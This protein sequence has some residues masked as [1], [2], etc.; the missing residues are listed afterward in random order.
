MHFDLFGGRDENSIP[1]SAMDCQDEQK[2]VDDMDRLTVTN[3]ARDAPVP[4]THS[5]PEPTFSSKKKPSE[6]NP[7]L[8]G[9]RKPIKQKKMAVSPTILHARENRG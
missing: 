3:H 1:P 5:A 6:H 8:R 4:Q 9:R 7:R 2:I